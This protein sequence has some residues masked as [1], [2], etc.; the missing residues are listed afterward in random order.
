MRAGVSLMSKAAGNKMGRCQG[1][2]PRGPV[3][4][5]PMLTSAQSDSKDRSVPESA[6][7]AVTKA[8]TTPLQITRERG[9]SG[10]GHDYE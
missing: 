2:G 5:E 6:V 10:L 7:G 1:A 8:D 3:D 4:D 9:P